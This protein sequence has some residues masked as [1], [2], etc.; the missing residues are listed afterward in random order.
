MERLVASTP[1]QALVSSRCNH[2]SLAGLSI[3]YY[4]FDLLQSDGRDLTRDRSTIAAPP[5]AI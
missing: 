3:V 5:S 2:A 4:A 1:R